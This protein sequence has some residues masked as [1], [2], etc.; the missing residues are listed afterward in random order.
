MAM[1]ETREEGGLFFLGLGLGTNF[2]YIV[3]TTKIPTIFYT[4][5]NKI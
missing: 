5:N 1:C 2:K 4:V 3:G